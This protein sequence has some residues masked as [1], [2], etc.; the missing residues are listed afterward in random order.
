[1]MEPRIGATRF[2]SQDV[3]QGKKS[4]FASESP[5]NQRL[6][7]AAMEREWKKWEEHK[8]TWPLT[9]GELRML[10]SRFPN[11]KIVG[12][13]CVLTPKEPDFKARLVV[14][15]CQEDPSMMR[16][17]SPTGSRDSFFPFQRCCSSLLHRLNFC[18]TCSS[19]RISSR[20][21]D[22]LRSPSVPL[23]VAPFSV[24]RLLPFCAVLGSVMPRSILNSSSEQPNAIVL[25]N[26]SVLSTMTSVFS[27]WFDHACIHKCKSEVK[28]RNFPF[29]LLPS[30]L[31]GRMSLIRHGWESGG[32]ADTFWSAVFM[33]FNIS[34]LPRMNSAVVTMSGHKNAGAAAA[35]VLCSASEF[36]ERLHSWTLLS[37]APLPCQMQLCFVARL[38]PT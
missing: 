33:L 4:I 12:T 20:S 26:F 7:L 10:K 21:L 15:G 27:S 1:M 3:R 23:S 36:F 35:L 5:E 14:Q 18:L 38:E 31:R 28:L 13:R 32:F 37:N 34:I 16:T 25:S 30:H 9:Q 22:M 19:D 8:A 11:L 17:D 6:L 24:V 2:Y 29:L